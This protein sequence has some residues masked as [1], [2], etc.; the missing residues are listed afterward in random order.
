MGSTCAVRGGA[1]GA[2][3]VEYVA[4]VTM[5][6]AVL[7]VVG[8]SISPR[9]HTLAAAVERALQRAAIGQ[10]R[11]QR[12]AG[13]ADRSERTTAARAQ[14]SSSRSGQRRHGDQTAP[15][16]PPAHLNRAARAGWSRDAAWKQAGGSYQATSGGGNARGRVTWSA[17]AGC[18]TVRGTGTVTDGGASARAAAQLAIAAAD[19]RAVGSARVGP[20]AA[21]EQVRASTLVGA[22]ARGTA[23]ARMSVDEQKVDLHGRAVA[24]A[25][26]RAE[27]R[28]AVSLLG[29]AL[30]HHAGAEGWAGAGA[31]GTARISRRGARLET[32]FGGGAAWGLGGAADT[33]VVIDATELITHPTVAL[34]PLRQL[35]VRRGYI[36]VNR[37]FEKSTDA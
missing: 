17:C 2:S 3:T 22:E 16:E 28:A 19:G 20:L 1:R 34:A 7:A 37:R 5:I 31:T 4:A 10:V 25:S 21:R 35:I 36:P 12:G 24:G 6:A 13:G 29:V 15:V 8:S 9:G 30:E 32:S 11:G 27:H 14:W 18:A 33:T 23:T 26:A